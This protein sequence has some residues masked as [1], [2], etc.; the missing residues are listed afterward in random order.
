MKFPFAAVALAGLT[1]GAGAILQTAAAAEHWSFQPV[2]RPVPPAADVAPIDA[3]VRQA[4]T[5]RGL[6]PSP[7]ADRATLCRRLYFDLSGLPPTPEELEAFVRDPNPR[8]YE[9]LVDK[10]LASPRFG[11][12]WAAPWL[13]AVRFAESDGF[14]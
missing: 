5:E 3:F 9:K 10:L 2:R 4:L 7:E 8:A 13:D 14:E 12:R 6:T 11:E 1:S